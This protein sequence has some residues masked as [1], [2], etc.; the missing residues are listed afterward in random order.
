MRPMVSSI[1]VVHSSVFHVD[2]WTEKL[3]KILLIIINNLGKEDHQNLSG[4]YARL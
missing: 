1:S 3:A 4:F 2:F